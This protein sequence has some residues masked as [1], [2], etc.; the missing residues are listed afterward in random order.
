MISMP[1]EQQKFSAAVDTYATTRMAATL[2]CKARKINVSGEFPLT[3]EG[4]SPVLLQHVHTVSSSW[5]DRRVIFL[6]LARIVGSET[7]SVVVDIHRAIRTLL[8]E[9]AETVS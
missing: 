3:E 1:T 2:I 5:R 8:S 9:S 4:K 7:L 6:S